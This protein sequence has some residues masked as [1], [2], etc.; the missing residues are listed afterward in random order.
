[1]KSYH[2]F[3]HL[4]QAK[5]KEPFVDPVEKIIQY[6]EKHISEEMTMEELSKVVYLNPDY[7]TRLFKKVEGISIC[8]YIVNR[9]IE[10]AKNFLQESDISIGDISLAVGY[11]NYP[12]FY[13]IFTKIT[14]TSPQQFRNLH[15]LDLDSNR[16]S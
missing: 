16:C 2:S 10:I 14:G 5:E 8:S 9:R 11:Y 3:H 12:S 6:I 1:M 13:K 7:L 15:R 4:A